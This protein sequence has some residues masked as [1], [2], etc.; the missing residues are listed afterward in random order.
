MGHNGTFIFA[1]SGINIAPNTEQLTEIALSSA[2]TAEYL[3]EMEPKVAMLPSLP[4]VVRAM[5]MRDKM[6]DAARM[7]KSNALTFA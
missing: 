5:R 2:Q 6:Y 4:R 1:D 7:A 3:C